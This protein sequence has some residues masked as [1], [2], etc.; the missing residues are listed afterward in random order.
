MNDM[1]PSPDDIHVNE[2]TLMIKQ[3]WQQF[4]ISEEILCD[5]DVKQ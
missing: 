4:V 3:Y 5:I 1:F 2:I